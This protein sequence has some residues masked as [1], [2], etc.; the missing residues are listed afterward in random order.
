M[1][2]LRCVLDETMSVET[3]AL[4]VT[5]KISNALIQPH[6][7][8]VCTAWFPNFKKKLKDK[9]Q[10]T[11]NKCIRFCLKLQYKEHISNEHLQKM[12]WLP[13]NQSFKQYVTSTVFKF[14]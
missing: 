9:L 6:F 8:Y 4:T 12:N 3:M 14:F 5:E 2:Y 7:D 1:N 13:V 10:V 11:Q